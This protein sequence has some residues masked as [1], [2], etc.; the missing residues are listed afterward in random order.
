MTIEDL[1]QIC[2]LHHASRNHLLTT[3]CTEITKAPAGLARLGQAA[4]PAGPRPDNPSTDGLSGRRSLGGAKPHGLGEV[5]QERCAA[6]IEATGPVFSVPWNSVE[7]RDSEM[8][9]N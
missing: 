1:L 5:R 3:K 6:S 8:N 9:H 4:P 2:W 7:V